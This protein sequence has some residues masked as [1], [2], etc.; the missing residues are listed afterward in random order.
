MKN[1]SILGDINP[2]TEIYRII[3]R[4]HF[5]QLFE[6]KRNTLVRPRRWEDPFENVFLKSPVLTSNGEKGQF[7]FYDDIYGQCWTLDG[8]SNAM[9]QI[10][11][12]GKDAVR[13]KTTVG[14]LIDSLRAVNGNWADTTCFIGKVKY[15]KVKDLREFGKKMFKWYDRAEGIAQSLLLKRNEFRYEKEVRL[16]YISP[17]S[18]TKVD[19]LYEYEI[20][21]L[22]L[23]S[24]A[25][26]DGRKLEIEEFKNNL[27]GEIKNR[28]GLPLGRI[29]RSQLYDPPKDFVVHID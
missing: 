29:Y 3:K 28:T 18:S 25:M 5:F 10:Y 2:D 22:E 4:D 7:E 16:I 24:Q 17:E 19:C 11:S 13:I 1:R 8:A 9:W 12:R 21:A 23:V 15:Q 20:D 14:K 6:D 26:V 27:K